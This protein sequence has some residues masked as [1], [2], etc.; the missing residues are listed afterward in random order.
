MSDNTQTLLNVLMPI[1]VA[2]ISAWAG[3]HYGTRTERRAFRKEYAVWLR[4]K[5]HETYM[6]FARFLSTEEHF[7]QSI[8]TNT[9]RLQDMRQELDTIN[10]LRQ[11]IENSQAYSETEIQNAEAQIERLERQITE[12]LNTSN[13]NLSQLSAEQNHMTYLLAL[14]APLEVVE[15]YRE[16]LDETRKIVEKARSLE[17]LPDHARSSAKV[18]VI[19]QMRTDI[20]L[21]VS[22]EQDPILIDAIRGFDR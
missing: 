18:R 19:V 16:Y 13:E 21:P 1:L 8:R 6:Q 4:G 3:Y 9:K 12:F 17:L 5:K 22:R 15:R 10:E 7:V 14:F 11:G 20:G 2:L